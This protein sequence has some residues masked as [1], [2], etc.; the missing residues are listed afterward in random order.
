[1]KSEGTSKNNILMF[2][3]GIGKELWLKMG[4]DYFPANTKKEVWQ[5]EKQQRFFAIQMRHLNK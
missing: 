4:E 2:L 1:M 5:L 3:G